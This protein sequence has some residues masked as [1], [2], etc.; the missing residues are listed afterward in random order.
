MS[1]SREA[2][3][4]KR[5]PSRNNPF[6]VVSMN[7]SR[8]DQLKAKIIAYLINSSPQWNPGTESEASMQLPY[9]L[10]PKHSSLLPW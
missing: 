9:R 1:T 7:S 2:L 3:E 6:S 8:V 4:L 10:F 5:K